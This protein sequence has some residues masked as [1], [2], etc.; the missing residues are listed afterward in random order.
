MRKLINRSEAIVD[1]MIDGYLAAYGDYVSR[2]EGRRVVTRA[3]PK[4]SGKVGLVIGNGSGH[5]PIA[6]GWVGRGMLDA[7]AL[8]EVFAAPPPDLILE[9][10]RAADRGAGVLLLISQHAGDVLNGEMAVELA[11]AEG[12][13]VEVLLMYDDISSAP[14]GSE[15]ERRGA[16]GTTFI[17]KIVGARAEEG[18]DLTELKAL[19]ERVRDQT[20]TLSAA[21]APGIS[22]LTGEPMFS[23]PEG[24][25]FLG[26][27]VHGEPG[28]RRMKGATADEVV[29]AM[30]EGILDDLPFE[31]GDEVLAFVNGAGGTTLME[32]LIVYRAVAKILG[33][34]S[35][36][37]YKPL[38]GEYV[39]TQEMAGFSIS[40]CRADE[41][42][43]RLWDAPVAVPFYHR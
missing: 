39:T 26:M 33:A 21:V 40:L 17:Y 16:P 38:V 41:E 31:A 43:K 4:E 24:E 10:I 19:G 18:A 6:V 9:A 32:L 5:E 2:V 15:S 3:V 7:N 11:R 25:I 12:F 14:K 29:A 37:A 34:R 20:R 42:M 13:E 36:R 8:G 28:F 35:L 30:M 1:E 27:G 23:L 22:P